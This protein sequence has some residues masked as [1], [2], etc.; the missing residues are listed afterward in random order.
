MVC[1][2]CGYEPIVLNQPCPECGHITVGKGDVKTTS[3]DTLEEDTYTPQFQVKK[4]TDEIKSSAMAIE[5]VFGVSPNNG[6]VKDNKK[7]SASAKTN[8]NNAKTTKGKAPNTQTPESPKKPKQQKTSELLK[9]AK[10][11]DGLRYTLAAVIVLFTLSLFFN[12]FALSGN[13]VN[14]GLVRDDITAPYMNTGLE[15]KSIAALEQYD[16]AILIFSGWDL[17][18]FSQEASG[19]YQTITG[20]SGLPKRSLPSV[21]QKYYMMA[22][23]LVLA[24]N[25][26]SIALVLI[27]KGL[28]TMAWVRNFAALNFVIVGLNY[29]CLRVPFIS[30]IAI[31][32]K[33]VIGDKSIIQRASMKFDGI[34]LEDVYYPYD[35]GELKGF[36]FALIMLAV[37]LLI[38]IVLTEVKNRRDEIA[39]DN[40]DL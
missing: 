6:K 30:M 37:W 34:A 27:F 9:G 33:E 24:I 7:P 15:G 10:V 31:R 19:L 39:I 3:Q 18:K 16:D 5:S 28:K 4:T 26:L 14:Y 23:G 8:K 1:A 32:A 11:I 21:I 38:A 20:P 22:I 29:L 17:F 13:A 35:L 12:W 40:G 2:K 36:Y 25:I